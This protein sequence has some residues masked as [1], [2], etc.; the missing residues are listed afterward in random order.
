MH[1][2]L[3]F[4]AVV[5]ASVLLLAGVAAP[6]AAETKSFTETGTFTFV[7]PAGVCSVT[8]DESGAQGGISGRDVESEAKPGGRTVATIPVTPGET[9]QI[10]VGGRGEKGTE[11]VDD[12]ADG[13]NTGGA[14]ATFTAPIDQP[15]GAGGF[16]GGGAGGAGFDLGGGGGGG[17][18]DVRQAAGGTG[19]VP[20]PT[21]GTKTSGTALADRVVV[22]GGGGGGGSFGGRAGVGGGASGGDPNGDGGGGNA[23]T[24]GSTSAGGGK[25]GTTSAGGAGGAGS[26]DPQSDEVAGNGGDGTSGNGG[27]G[28]ELDSRGGGG[29]GGGGYFGGGGGGGVTSGEGSAGGGGGGSSFAAAN[30]TSVTFT[31]GVRQGDGVVILTWTQTTD[32]A[33][34]VACPVAL[35]PRFTG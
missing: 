28:G 21:A 35:N 5:G 7:V 24:P 20:C 25:V 29:G 23:L 15:G 33:P 18:S 30:A 27:G 34:G 9:L 32:F 31:A 16:N 14:Q 1:L 3:K 11:E 17:A 19:C 10:N 2:P 13:Q 8:V 26:T 22:A 12:A 6:I 4:V